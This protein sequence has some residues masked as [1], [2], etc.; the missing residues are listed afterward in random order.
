MFRKM[1]LILMAI[2]IAIILLNPLM[3]LEVKRLLYSISL[4][5]KSIIGL[6]LPLIIFGLLFKSVVMLA[7]DATRIVFLI[8][9]LVCG[10]NF[11]STFISHYVGIYIYQFDLSMI[12]PIESDSLKPLWLLNFP[13]IIS[14]DKIVFSSIILGFIS[15][16]F[17]AEVAIGL[18]FKIEVFVAKILRLFIYVIPLFIM[19]FIVKLQFD[20]VLGIII[21]DYMFIFVTIAF[22]QFGYIFLA[23]FILSNCRVKEFIASLSNM[24]PASISGFSAMSSVVSMPLSIIG[25]ENN[26]NNKAL[27]RT[28]VPITVNIHL[29]GDCFAI[30][31]LAYA[32]L[33]SY[34]LAEPTLFNY[35][36]FTF[37]FVLAKFSVAAIPGG[38][39][40]VMLPILEQYLGF[41]TNMMSLITALYILFD[42]VITCA[43]VLG[44]GAFV[45]LIDNI[46]V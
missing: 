17:C 11:C 28:V 18:A 42:P 46:L 27:A 36:I 34:G 25:A 21:K 15:S 5:I 13:N 8:L 44:N 37:Y 9:L 14:N 7:K 40:I 32:I 38:G 4:S 33:K 31:I 12:S 10:S 41:N 30:P 16:K 22:A 39:I 43:N 19:G 45:K 26:T 1:P 6:F 35:L 23:Y 20:E 29:V 2:I 3:S 24:M